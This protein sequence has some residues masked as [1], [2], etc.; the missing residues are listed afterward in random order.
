[1]SLLVGVGHKKRSGKDTIANRLVDKH[2]FRRVSW[3]DSLKEAA[4]IIFGWT[5]EHLYG[6]LKERVDPYWGFSPRWALQTLGTEACRNNIH[7]QIWV[8][9]AWLRIE[10]IRD[11]NPGVGIVVPDVRFPNEADFIREKGGYLW[12]VNRPGL[13][14]DE[15]AN[16]ASETALDDYNGWNSILENTHDLAHLYGL[17][18]TELENLKKPKERRRNNTRVII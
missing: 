16:H 14:A 2:Q 13:A 10:K 6:R 15:A 3:A 11:E 12:K 4:R 7:Q 5:D 1:M 8:K 18:D 9:S 17:V